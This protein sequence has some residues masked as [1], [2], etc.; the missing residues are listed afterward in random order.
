MADAPLCTRTPPITGMVND[1]AGMSS[2]DLAR[3]L[4]SQSIFQ[5]AL[6]FL[7][8]S[9]ILALAQIARAC[10]RGRLMENPDKRPVHHL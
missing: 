9:L 4:N 3:G 5:K 1:N 2:P 7:H 8:E 6:V 10:G